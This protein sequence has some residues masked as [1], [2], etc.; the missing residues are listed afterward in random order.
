[1]KFLI[2]ENEFNLFEDVFHAFNMIFYGGKL[3]WIVKQ[4]S[5]E[6]KD[7]QE[8]NNYDVIFV[9]IDL[10]K[11]S[12]KDGFEIMNDI[13]KVNSNANVVVL[14]GH[15]AIEKKLEERLDHHKRYKILNK[16]ITIEELQNS[17]KV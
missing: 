17:V 9:D 5:Q 8:I 2:F 14:T 11:N 6:L 16:P 4:S 12:I 7:I 3:S 13:Y 1:M 10:S 15:G